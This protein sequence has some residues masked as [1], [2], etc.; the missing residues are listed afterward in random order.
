MLWVSEI[1]EEIDCCC[2]VAGVVGI[3]ETEVRRSGKIYRL[4]VLRVEQPLG[5]GRMYHGSVEMRVLMESSEN[6][7]ELILWQRN[8]VRRDA[9]AFWGKGA[10]HLAEM[11]FGTMKL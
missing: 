5:G 1:A 2:A 4:V 10:H 7:Q 6:A 3:F 8:P 11:M 9:E